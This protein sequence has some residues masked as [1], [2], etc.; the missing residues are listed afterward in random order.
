[1][2]QNNHKNRR[3]RDKHGERKHNS[4]NQENV[5]RSPSN[6]DCNEDNSMTGAG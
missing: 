2:N 5:A 3:Q 1:M 6:S 4:K